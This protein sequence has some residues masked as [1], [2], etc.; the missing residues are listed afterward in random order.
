[1]IH[2]TNGNPARV[3]GEN[4]RGRAPHGPTAVIAPVGRGRRPPQSSLGYSFVL[5]E[6]PLVFRNRNQ[7]RLSQAQFFG[8]MW[9]YLMES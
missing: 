8:K 5:V 4:L 1:M 9:R 6:A 3:A 2:R 7:V